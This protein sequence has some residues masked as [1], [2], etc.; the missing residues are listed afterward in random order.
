MREKILQ[1]IKELKENSKKRNFSQ[2]FDMIVLLKEVDLKK[3]ENKISDEIFLPNGFGEEVSIKIFSDTIRP[4]GVEAISSTE[5]ARIAKD[6]RAAKKLVKETEFFLAEPKLMPVVAK[7][8]GQIMGPRGKLPKV[9]AGDVKSVIQNLKKSVKFRVKDSPV[10]QFKVGKESM[11]DEDVA[12]N[13]EAAVKHLEN[14]LPKGKSNISK[15]MLKLTMSKPVK[16]EI[17]GEGRK[18]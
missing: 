5:L 16:V 2:T 4:E 18:A 13:I 17:Y 14:K 1:A 8:L 7:S 9:I 3:P 12:E 15:V 6:K 11:D 10:I